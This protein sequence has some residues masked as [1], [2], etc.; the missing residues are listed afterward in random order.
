MVFLWFSRNHKNVMHF[1][2][3]SLN[4]TALPMKSRYSNKFQNTQKLSKFHFILSESL[5]VTGKF[6]PPNREIRK[7]LI[8][9]ASDF[10]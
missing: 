5:L 10:I 7:S 2:F 4:T 8:H 3:C 9:F 1:V 6:K